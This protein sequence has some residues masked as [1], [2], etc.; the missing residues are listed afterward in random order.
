M[1]NDDVLAKCPEC[2]SV[3]TSTTSTEITCGTCGFC[4]TFEYEDAPQNGPS[5]AANKVLN[6]A[7][8]RAVLQ[9]WNF[10]G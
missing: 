10:A 1:F 6:M 2:G 9:R 7:K 3:E 8:A 5:S 4:E